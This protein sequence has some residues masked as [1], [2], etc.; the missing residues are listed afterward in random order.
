MYKQNMVN[1]EILKEKLRYKSLRVF[2]Q[3]QQKRLQQKI[4]AISPSQLYKQRIAF[5][6]TIL[7]C[8]TP[9]QVGSHMLPGPYENHLKLP[10]EIAELGSVMHSYPFL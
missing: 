7:R 3:Q 10:Q 6:G 5:A 9:L 4:D 8:C 2:G 1:T